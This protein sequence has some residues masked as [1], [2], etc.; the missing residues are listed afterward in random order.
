MILS[1]KPS[2]NLN[3][4]SACTV[5]IERRYS[6]SCLEKG[7]HLGYYFLL[8]LLLAIICST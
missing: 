3:D 2:S 5:A 6:R 4:T 8:L 1:T 7:T